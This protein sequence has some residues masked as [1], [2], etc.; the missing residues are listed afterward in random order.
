ME[1]IGFCCADL[2]PKV[3]IYPSLVQVGDV[4]VFFFFHQ[5]ERELHVFSSVGEL[6]EI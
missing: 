6:L 4:L 3:C 5:I 1:V 2:A